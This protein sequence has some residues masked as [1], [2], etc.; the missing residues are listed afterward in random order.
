VKIE[1]KIS[2]GWSLYGNDKITRQGDAVFLNGGEFP[3]IKK[4]FPERL[5]KV[6]DWEGNWH[7]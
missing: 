4:N 5:Y 3:A 2:L 6:I 7:S 1:F